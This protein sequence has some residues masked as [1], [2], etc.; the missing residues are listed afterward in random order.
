VAVDFGRRFQEVNEHAEAILAAKME[1]RGLGFEGTFVDENELIKWQV[2]ARHLL[3]MACG[4]D[5]EHFLAFKSNQDPKFVGDSN[6]AVLLRQHA[7]FLAAKNDYDGGYLVQL[8]DLIQS[9]VFENELEQAHEL[10]RANYLIA[11]AV[12]AGT[13]LETTLRQMCKDHQIER[14]KLDKMNTDLAKAGVYNSLVQK[15]ITALAAVRNSAAH[16]KPNEFTRDDVSAM[17]RDVERFVTSKV[18]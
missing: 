17:I 13:V 5:S 11:A 14:G 10:F 7:V 18:V 15:R 3:S 2:N 1:T 4:R 16:G 9:E 6:Y 8:R 12:I